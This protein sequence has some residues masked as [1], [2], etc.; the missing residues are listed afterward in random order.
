MLHALVLGATGAVG[1]ALVR[2]L[3]DGSR[4]RSVSIFVR[5][6]TSGFEGHRGAS[7]LSVHVVDHAR[8]EAEVM[9]EMTL[10]RDAQLGTIA[11]F[12][13][14][15][16]GQPRK[17]SREELRRVDVGIAGAFARGCRSAGVSHFSLLT[18]AGADSSSR[19]YYAKVKGD[20]E[21]A[22]AALGFPRASYFRPSLLVT[23]E[24][25]YG[26]QD[27]VTQ[28]VFP[29]ISPFLPSRYHEITV[30]HLA[31]A[32]RANAERDGVSGEEVLEYADFVRVAGASKDAASA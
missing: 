17:V 3:L 5:R 16:V 25:R 32:M 1:S 23:R 30:E 6:P 7:K 9:C 26:V 29:R 21:Q 10:R 4:W 2:E 31:R 28:A 27:R 8:L 11:A 18:A 12:C 22:V 20:A 19:L 14:L 13:T 15:G 24:L